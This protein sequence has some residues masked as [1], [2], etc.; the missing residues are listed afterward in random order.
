[1]HLYF[2]YHNQYIHRFAN[3][4]MLEMFAFQLVKN[5]AIGLI[6]IFV[7]IF[8]YQQ[9]ISIT[10][11]V[12]LFAARGL[13][14]MFTALFIARPLIFHI[15]FKHSF[16]A[17]IIISAFSYLAL[18]QNM[19]T[20]WLTIWLLCEAI[21]HGIYSTDFNSYMS[22][23]A[24]KNKTGR[25]IAFLSILSH[26]INIVAPFVG[27]ILIVSLG[28]PIMFKV[29][30][31][32]L[33]F[34]T[35]PLFFSKETSITNQ[36][37]LSAML[38]VKYFW[39]KK[40]KVAISTIG[41]ALDSLSHPFWSIYVY[42]LLGGITLFGSLLSFVSFLQVI[43]MYISGTNYDK[44][45]STFRLGINGGILARCVA[46]FAF[47]AP[48]A[49]ASDILINLAGPLYTAPRAAALYNQLR[50]EETISMIVGHETIW[51]LFNAAALLVLVPFIYL[52]GWYSFPLFITGVI[53]GKFIIKSQGI[54]AY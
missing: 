29:A 25:E 52:L 39:Q 8:L 35:V 50:G 53:A 37:R 54:G 28:F 21:S 13:I 2:Q 49:V 6:G 1:M 51:N 34:S 18:S 19:S 20:S 44:H 47:S 15:G 46:L 9:G 41:D 16:L 3:T 23:C 17:A 38:C 7:P 14:H 24:D 26:T 30:C 45:K 40:R 48:I 22:L 10:I 12:L 31:F 36:K 5:L 42:F 33:I 43:V 27:A 32:L 11:I 4:E